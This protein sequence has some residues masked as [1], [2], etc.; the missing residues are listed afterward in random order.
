VGL[1]SAAVVV[2]PATMI[3]GAFTGACGQPV[4]TCANLSSADE[5]LFG[6]NW[7]ESHTIEDLQ[8]LQSSA[9]CI[10]KVLTHRK[11]NVKPERDVIRPFF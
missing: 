5:H 10:Q 11:S 8:K 9:S 3:L 4:D 1:E 6:S 7:I 2:H